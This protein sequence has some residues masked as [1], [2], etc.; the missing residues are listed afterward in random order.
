MT[1]IPPPAAG[2][3][4]AAS[5]GG[6]TG[7][8]VEMGGGGT[9]ALGRKAEAAAAARR[10]A[11][12]KGKAGAG[13][14]PG[15]ASPARA[16]LV[17]AAVASSPVAGAP[18]TLTAAAGKVGPTG[19]PLAKPPALSGPGAWKEN[20][21]QFVRS[22]GL[23]D[24][25]KQVFEQALL[26]RP[27]DVFSFAAAQMRFLADPF[28]RAIL[29][30]TRMKANQAVLDKKIRDM[31]QE[32]LAI[33][34][35]DLPGLAET[36][37]RNGVYHA[38]GLV[39]KMRQIVLHALDAVDGAELIKT[40]DRRHFIQ[41]TS[42]EVALRAVLLV[43]EGVADFNARQQ[44]AEFHLQPSVG[45][46]MGPVIRLPTDVFGD[47][48]NTASK[49]GED[50]AA[51][52]QI[53]ISD[54]AFAELDKAGLLPRPGAAGSAPMTLA[55]STAAAAAGAP[56]SKGKGKGKGKAAASSPTPVKATLSA[57]PAGASGGAPSPLPA[58]MR[59]PRAKFWDDLVYEEAVRT[60]SRVEL[61]FY[62]VERV[63]PASVHPIG[64]EPLALANEEPRLSDFGNLCLT[65]L[66]RDVNVPAIHR[67]L[68]QGNETSAFVVVSD[69]SGFT[70]TT[71][72]KGI[73]HF[74]SLIFTM[75]QA[76]LPLIA[77]HNGHFLKFEADNVFAA[78]ETGDDA[79]AFALESI[80]VMRDDV[81][82][83]GT[84]DERAPE[85]Q[86]HL[87][88]GIHFG[89]LVIVKDEEDLYGEAIDVAFELGENQCAPDACL[90]SSAVYELLEDQ[91]ALRLEP[92]QCNVDGATWGCFAVTSRAEDAAMAGESGSE[93][94]VEYEYEYEYESA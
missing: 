55:Q 79:V 18:G 13:G 14:A 68:R 45:I 92:H 71:R 93:N 82:A 67:A 48:V 52:G 77:A 5:Q 51:A 3:S 63:V 21:A 75:R 50:I 6:Y 59:R 37:Q 15:A 58:A 38:L 33:A 70:R 46:S 89:P 85:E 74:L 73:L 34:I 60:I 28:T 23:I 87:A 19:R 2:G 24:A 27:D 91:A 36:A 35:L 12:G 62:T 49:L 43:L 57:S 56:A 53:L 78:F 69:M 88:F 17:P 20:Y 94:G 31:Y 29:G 40:E 47:A 8:A 16:G 11:K 76:V 64:T 41:A 4:Y 1:S 81:N 22:S 32:R 7:N 83:E 72:A 84:S 10:A 25:F 61:H 42:C 30:R 66:N 65:Q 44:S 39:M 54:K 9:S 90:I 80:R 86:I 26:R